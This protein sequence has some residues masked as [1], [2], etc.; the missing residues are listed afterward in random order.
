MN[1][2]SF[3]EVRDNAAG[4]I[5]KIPIRNLWVLMLY[6]SDLYRHI[7]TTSSDIEENPEDL[8]D[9]IAEILTNAVESRLMRNLSFGYEQKTAKLNRVRGRINVLETER[10]HLLQRG[11]IACSFDDLT[12]NTNRNRYVRAALDKLSDMGLNARNSK[13]CRFLSRT[14]ESLGVSCIKPTSYSYHSERFG[15]HDQA[16]QKMVA[17]AELVFSLSIPNEIL[18]KHRLPSPDK[19]IEWLRKLFEKAIAGF[20]SVNLSKKD[21]KVLDGKKLNWQISEATENVLSIL[22]SMKT[23]IVIEQRNTGQFLVIDTKFNSITKKGWYKDQTLRSG[24]LYQMYTYLRSQENDQLATTL[25]A[26]GMLLHP[27]IN[28][29]MSESVT[30][31]GHAIYFCTVNLANVTQSIRAQLLEQLRLAF[32]YLCKEIV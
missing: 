13:K 16:D 31:Q 11:S 24:Y 1:N 18:G 4:P 14:L 28:N 12:I 30:I 32:P 26:S 7:D 25:G 9:M 20:Y 17:A 6:A 8:V 10:K 22:P 29:E 23:D 15:R 3:L 27:T 5:H 2:N 19:Q 21:W